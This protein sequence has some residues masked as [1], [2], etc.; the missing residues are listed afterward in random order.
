MNHQRGKILDFHL[1]FDDSLTNVYKGEI[2]YFKLLLCED[3][4]LAIPMRNFLDVVTQQ[5]QVLAGKT[6]RWIKR[7]LK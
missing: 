3:K 7:L 4:R 6:S 5:P 1:G 2:W